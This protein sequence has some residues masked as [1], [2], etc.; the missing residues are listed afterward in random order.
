MKYLGKKG[1]NI[2]RPVFFRI[3]WE[4][5]LVRKKKK[6]KQILAKTAVM[7]KCDK[8]DIKTPAPAGT[9]ESSS[10]TANTGKKSGRKIKIGE[11]FFRQ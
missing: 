8:I 4:V 11:I 7:Q 6:G 9:A 10:V 3:S 2:Y 1:F 5:S